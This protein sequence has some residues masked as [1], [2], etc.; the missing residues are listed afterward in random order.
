MKS[1]SESRKEILPLALERQRLLTQIT[2]MKNIPYLKR[3]SLSPESCMKT[4]RS[5]F[6]LLSLLAGVNGALAQTIMPQANF[7]TLVSFTDT[8]GPNNGSP[9]G[10]GSSGGMVL[11]SDGNFY[12]TTFAGGLFYPGAPTWQG[13]GTIFKLMPDGTFTPFYF[14]NTLTNSA[15]GNLD[16]YWPIGN[17]INGAD[18]NLYGT[19]TEGGY[20]GIQGTAAGTVFQI[21]MN[22]TLTVLH[23]FGANSG[24]DN[25]SNHYGWTNY[26]GLNPE[27]GVVQGTDGNFYG[28]T[29]YGGAYG[30][31]T[32]FQLTPGGIL[33]VLHAFSGN[34][35]AGTNGDGAQPSGELVEGGDGNFYGMTAY[36][37]S[38]DA[39]TVYRVAPDG[40]FTNLVMFDVRNG[41][42]NNSV[43]GALCKGSDG[44]IYGTTSGGGPYGNGGDGTIFKITTNGTFRTL[45]EFGTA[46]SD[47]AWPRA[48][49]IQ[50]SDGN[51]Y[52]TTENAVNVGYGT[53]FQITTNGVLTTLYTFSAPTPGVGSFGGNADGC[54]PESSLT[55]GSNGDLY[56]MAN[57]G[58]AYGYGTLFRV[59]IP[60]AFQ[61]ATQ[62]KLPTAASCGVSAPL[63]EQRQLSIHRL[64]CW[65]ALLL[66]VALDDLLGRAFPHRPDIAP[67]TPKL[68]TPKHA[69]N[70]WMHTKHLPR[71]DALHHLHNP[72]RRPTPARPNKHMHMI[73]VRSHLLDLIPIPL[74]NLPQRL[75][76]GLPIL[77]LPKHLLAV[78]D[79]HDHVIPDLIHT[80][81][82]E[83]NFHSNGLYPLSLSLQIPPRSKLRGILCPF[84]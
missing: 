81:A 14:F 61:S 51:F 66:N 70:F 78:L 38:Y 75:H 11:A 25:D 23:P 44:S 62:M 39:G 48:G 69:T 67:V 18:G 57:Y 80:M 17:L 76:Q 79:A 31:G 13:F 2:P 47:G 40:T 36:G 82:A 30:N 65:A 24:Y 64:F 68:S 45:Y 16:G 74:A 84:R 71:C 77:R 72:R 42:I 73:P 37:G 7:K 63:P 29:A 10:T 46:S 27:G 53:V 6:G 49:L 19:T 21:T 9:G 15:S 1:Y 35:Y 58:G 56:G 22:G 52:G 26:D 28:T 50:G 33:T 4:L 12:G 59:T 60:P 5:L 34:Y 55:Q 8:N 20:W 43:C 83:F 32:V 41:A 3:S 54:Y